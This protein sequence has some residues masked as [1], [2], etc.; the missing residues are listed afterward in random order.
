MFLRH[1][2]CQFQFFQCDVKTLKELTRRSGFPPLSLTFPSLHWTASHPAGRGGWVKLASPALPRIHEVMGCGATALFGPRRWLSFAH[3]NLPSPLTLQIITAPLKPLG[4]G[5]G[6]GCR[7]GGGGGWGYG[8]RTVRCSWGW[9]TT[10]SGG[11]Q[12]GHYRE[13]E[14]G[15]MWGRFKVCGW[16]V[17]KFLLLPSNLF[18]ALWRVFVEYFSCDRQLIRHS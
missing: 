16:Q 1:I 9:W 15:W 10:S 14:E 17:F 6:L 5:S 18:L 8:D 11:G 7:D 2:F 4:P 13:M 3:C 12:T